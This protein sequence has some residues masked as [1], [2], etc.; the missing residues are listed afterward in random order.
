MQDQ[1]AMDAA[2]AMNAELDYSLSVTGVVDRQLYF[3]LVEACRYDSASTV[4]W[5]QARLGTLLDRV[6]RGE[7]LSLFDLATEGQIDVGSEGQLRAWLAS[8][9][10]WLSH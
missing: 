6:V 7:S 10:L 1:A 3:R 8:N 9:S 2:I 5:A 4:G